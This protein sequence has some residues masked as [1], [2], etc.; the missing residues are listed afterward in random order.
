MITHL[1]K[2]IQDLINSREREMWLQ[3]EKCLKS[4]EKP[5][6]HTHTYTR[7]TTL[8]F[9]FKDCFTIR[10]QVSDNLIF[11]HQINIHVILELK[12]LWFHY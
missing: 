5:H 3:L 9:R 8:Y 11:F 12:N 10:R 7:T 2:Y 1:Q 4:K 6:V